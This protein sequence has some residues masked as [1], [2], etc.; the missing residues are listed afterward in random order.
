MTTIGNVTQLVCFKND[1]DDDD[2]DDDDDLQKCHKT[3]S[4]YVWNAG[5]AAAGFM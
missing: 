2:I 3:N 5:L 4:Q 1:D